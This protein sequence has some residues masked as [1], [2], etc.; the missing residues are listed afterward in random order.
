MKDTSQTTVKNDDNPVWSPDEN[1]EIYVM[2]ADG[3]NQQQLTD[4]GVPDSIMYDSRSYYF[5]SCH[6]GTYFEL[7][8][9]GKVMPT[10][11]GPEAPEE[12]DDFQ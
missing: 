12:A 2:D 10:S 11:G 6:N 9:S 8:A 4:T 7:N 3:S 5:L 1:D